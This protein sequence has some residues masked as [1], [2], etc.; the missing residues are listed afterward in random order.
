M[1]M[2]DPTDPTTANALDVDRH[3]PLLD[4]GVPMDVDGHSVGAFLGRIAKI[5]QGVLLVDQLDRMNDISNADLLD[6]SSPSPP[7]SPSPSPSFV[8]KYSTIKS[9][10]RHTESNTMSP[11]AQN[12]E[13]HINPN[14]KHAFETFV[15][16]T[17]LESRYYLKKDELLQENESDD[18]ERPMRFGHPA[19]IVV[20]ENADQDLDLVDDEKL[21]FQLETFGH[22]K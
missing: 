3:R 9:L 15:K 1:I 7:P 5:E 12:I 4:M 13:A 19:T 2:F 16:Q 17:Q 21:G 8:T 11:V 18:D 6:V 22:R 20:L 10:R 14:D